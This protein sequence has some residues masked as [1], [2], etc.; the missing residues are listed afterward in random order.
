MSAAHNVTATFN[1]VPP[2]PVVV[3]PPVVS[4]GNLFCGVQHRGK[5]LGLKCKTEFSGPGN[6]VWTFA[7]YNP[8]P[9]HAAA[10]KAKM[11]VLGAI[12]R[13]ITKA[14]TQTVVFE[15]RAGARTRKLYKQVV[16]LKLKSIRVTLTFVDSTGK[17][18]TTRHLRLKL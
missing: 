1:T 4:S 16:K 2:P 5:C 18:Q 12:K 17:H 15:L 3:T 10:A 11:V 13:E 7:A 6:A 14:G 9:G 8:S